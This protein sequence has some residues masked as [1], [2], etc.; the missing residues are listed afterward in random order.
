MPETQTTQAQDAQAA[1]D[2]TQTQ[3]QT[4][5]PAFDPKLLLEEVGQLKAT[6]AQ[7]PG[8][9]KRLVAESAKPPAAPAPKEPD[10]KPDLNVKVSALE[11]ELAAM[12]ERT[13]VSEIKSSLGAAMAHHPLIEGVQPEVI[14]SILEKQVQTRDDGTHVM[15]VK[16]TLPASGTVIEDEV[17]IASGVA[18]FFSTN[19]GLVR[20]SIKSGVTA[21]PKAG[22]PSKFTSWAQLAGNPNLLQEALRTIGKAGVEALQDAHNSQKKAKR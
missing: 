17:D 22:D 2:Q 18:A 10:G 9:V 12:R 21:D 6:I 7:M 13:R 20:A 14:V 19:K 3:D 5:E 1:Q 4:Q 15:K 16:K 8:M 11:T